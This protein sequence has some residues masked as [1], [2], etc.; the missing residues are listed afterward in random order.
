MVCLSLFK[1]TLHQYP[2]MNMTC[3]NHIH[4][5]VCAVIPVVAET[6]GVNCW[7]IRLLMVANVTPPVPVLDVLTTILP[8]VVPLMAGTTLGMV[9]LAIAAPCCKQTN[10]Q[11]KAGNIVT[12]YKFACYLTKV[13]LNTKNWCQNKYVK[14]W[15]W[16]FSIFQN[17]NLTNTVC[18]CIHEQREKHCLKKIINLAFHELD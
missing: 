5:T 4:T 1:Q 6:T 17:I 2:V 11:S 16:W 7:V 18:L 12:G 8:P 9:P 13:C 10:N 3:F 14:K 15:L